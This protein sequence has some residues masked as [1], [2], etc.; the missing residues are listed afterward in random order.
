MSTSEEAEGSKLFDSVVTVVFFFFT[1]TILMS[2]IYALMSIKYETDLQAEAE[3]SVVKKNKPAEIKI[4]EN[5]STSAKI[6]YLTASIK[7][8]QE[9][10]AKKVEKIKELSKSK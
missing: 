1:F 9:M 5:L 4:P 2:I 7:I 3:K 6:D 8:D 10:I